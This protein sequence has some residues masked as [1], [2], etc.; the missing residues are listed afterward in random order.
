MRNRAEDDLT[1]I[2]TLWEML[3]NVQK[4][5]WIRNVTEHIGWE[6]LEKSSGK[7][8]PLCGRLVQPRETLLYSYTRK[9]ITETKSAF[10]SKD[11]LKLSVCLTK[12][13]VMKTYLVL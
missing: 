4:L 6:T 5:T 11:K 12:Y 1:A 2:T 8:N 7:P 10:L 9:P 3:L 13:H